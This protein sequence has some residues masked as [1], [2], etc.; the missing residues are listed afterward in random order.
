[1]RVEQLLFII[2]NVEPRIKFGTSK[3][4]FILEEV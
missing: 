1:M 2:Y 3:N 4:D